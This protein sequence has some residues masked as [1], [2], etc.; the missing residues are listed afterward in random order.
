M[1]QTFKNPVVQANAMQPKYIKPAQNIDLDINKF[2]SVYKK[3]SEDFPDDWGD[4]MDYI[5]QELGIE[6]P[7][8]VS[9]V[10]YKNGK[11]YGLQ[12]DAEKEPYEIKLYDVNPI[13]DNKKSQAKFQP[14]KEYHDINSRQWFKLNKIDGDR[15]HLTSPG[16]N[17]MMSMD[18]FEKMIKQS[19]LN[20]PGTWKQKKVNGGK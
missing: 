2:D 5:K 12:T 11:L 19:P 17:R 4:K 6:I 14:G 18:E 16:G 1:A 15:V 9:D 3:A 7:E 20:E 10:W 8:T 13:S